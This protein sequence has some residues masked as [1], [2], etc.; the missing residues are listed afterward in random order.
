MLR[1]VAQNVQFLQINSTH[2]ARTFNHA[3]IV[4]AVAD[5]Q[6]DRLFIALDQLNYLSFLQWSNSATDDS[7]T[8][9]A[10]VQQQQLHL[11]L[12]RMNLTYTSTNYRAAGIND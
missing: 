11:L 4:G 6:R 1:F 10:R 2:S 5:G 7:L 3:D 12:Q 8:H 9:T